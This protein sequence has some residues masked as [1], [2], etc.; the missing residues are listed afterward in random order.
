[1][2]STEMLADSERCPFAPKISQ[3]VTCYDS[4]F[5]EEFYKETV[6]KICQYAL[7]FVRCYWCRYE[8]CWKC[9]SEELRLV[10][11]KS[12]YHHWVICKSGIGYLHY[13]S[14]KVCQPT[15]NDNFNS[16]CL[17]LVIFGTKTTQWIC[18]WKVVLFLN[19]PVQCTYFTTLG[20]FK[21][22]EITNLAAHYTYASAGVKL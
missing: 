1:M 8:N 19:S 18:H 10:N 22:F 13:V 6:D 20:N 17:I 5:S 7:V 4:A 21:T 3:D 16:S 14:E 11:D 15:A 9:W 12:H 2:C